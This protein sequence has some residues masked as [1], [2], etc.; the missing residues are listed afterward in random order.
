MLV[1]N[2][3]DKKDT[4]ALKQAFNHGLILKKYIG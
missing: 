4:R 2:L 1:C 3:Y